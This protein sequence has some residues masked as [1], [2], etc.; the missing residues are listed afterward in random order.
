MIVKEITM[1]QI[2]LAMETQLF[3]PMT[4]PEPYWQREELIKRNISRCLKC[5]RENID[6]SDLPY[7][8]DHW[9][10]Y[11]VERNLKNFETYLSKLHSLLDKSAIEIFVKQQDQ[12]NSWHLKM[13]EDEMV[14]MVNSFYLTIKYDILWAGN[15]SV[16][17][18][19]KLSKDEVDYD[20]LIRKFPEMINIF[21]STVIPFFESINV[22]KNRAETLKEAIKTFEQGHYRATSSLILIE[23]EGLVRQLGGFLIEKQNI[24]RTKLKKK[25]H[26]LDSFLKDIPWLDDFEIDEDHLMF[27]SGDFVFKVN[28]EFDRT[29]KISLKTRL[30]FLR[31][32]FKESRNSIL[33]GDAVFGETWDLYVNFSA[34]L[35][36]HSVIR[37]YENLY[38]V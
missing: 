32:R 20:N 24:E 16:S 19:L 6:A 7:E 35:E 10:K 11:A 9:E 28:R 4:D 31:R 26:S 17:D 8:L 30:N 15:I 37:Y 33:H 34:L 12:K 14:F 2:I 36:V 23:L 13:E 22:Y 1:H 5:I 27:L 25:Y 21:K 18:V 3:N 38:R 29:T